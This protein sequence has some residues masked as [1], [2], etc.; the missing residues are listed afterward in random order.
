MRYPIARAMPFI[1]III[2]LLLELTYR[3]PYLFDK[4]PGLISLGIIK[5]FRADNLRYTD[6]A[7]AFTAGLKALRAN[8]LAT[9]KTELKNA[10]DRFSAVTS[11]WS[12]AKLPGGLGGADFEMLKQNLGQVVAALETSA[13]S[14]EMPQ[15]KA[16]EAYFSAM[17]ANYP[18]NSVLE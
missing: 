14:K 4:S 10:S 11:V 8:D 6:G 17:K 13:Y 12:N 7:V 16:L 15:A 3:V 1:L 9:A 18:G 2:L 5:V